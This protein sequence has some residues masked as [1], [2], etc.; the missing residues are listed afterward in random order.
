MQN[1]QEELKQLQ[2]QL[3]DLLE[4]KKQLIE[5]K[6][7]IEQKNS[8]E[9]MKLLIIQENESIEKECQ[10]LID[11]LT[12]KE[13]TLHEFTQKYIELRSSFHFNSA[14]IHQQ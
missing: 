12:K 10:E 7:E 9:A 8:I 2:N 14:L 3:N 4:E 6:R 13:I 5:K 1:Q 11:K